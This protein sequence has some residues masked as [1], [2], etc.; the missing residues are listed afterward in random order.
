MQFVS[1]RDL[2]SKSSEIWKKVRKERDL[3]VTSNGRPVAILS[4]VSENNLEESLNAIRTSRA[5]QAVEN[6]QLAARRAHRDEM[7][8]A[9]IEQEIAAVRKARRR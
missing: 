5:I 8:D 4:G 1:V 2:R 6:M 3:V 7:S 9:E